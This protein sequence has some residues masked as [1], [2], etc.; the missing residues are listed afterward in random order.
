MKEQNVQFKIK[1]SAGAF[2]KDMERAGLH[3]CKKYTKH[4]AQMNKAAEVLDRYDEFSSLTLSPSDYAN[5]DTDYGIKKNKFHMGDERLL[6]HQVK[7]TQAFLK[8]LRGFGLLADV[9]GSGKTYEAGAVLSE[10]AAKGKIATALIIVPSQVYNTWIE[11]LENGF[12]L[13]KG[14]LKTLGKEFSDENFAVGEDSMMRPT[15]P[16][17]VKTKATFCKISIISPFS[18]NIIT[19]SRKIMHIIK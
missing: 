2:D 15:A 16:I 17:I 18:I 13:G 11:V 7:A 14:D 19:K 3:D 6:P 9:V 10:L 4:V 1:F 8:E 12:G 5:K